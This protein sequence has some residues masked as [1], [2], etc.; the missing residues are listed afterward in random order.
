MR[1]ALSRLLATILP[2][3]L[4]GTGGA[5]AAEGEPPLD[6]LIQLN[7]EELLGAPVEKVE[8]GRVTLDIR[9]LAFNRAFEH[10]STPGRGF[11]ANIEDVK[12]NGSLRPLLHEAEDGF[13]AVGVGNGTAVSKFQFSD[14]FKVSFHLKTGGLSADSVFS[15]RVNQEDAKSFI[16]TDFFRSLLILDKGKK[17]LK[18]TTR[19]QFQPDPPSWFPREKKIPVEISYQGKNQIAVAISMDPKTAR[20]N[21]E[22]RGG[23][24]G[25]RRGKEEAKPGD[26]ERI[27]MV[28]QDGVESPAAGK[29][30]FAFSRVSFLLGNLR[31]EG[32][33]DPAWVE[34]AIEKLRKENKLKIKEDPKPADVAAKDEKAKDTKKSKGSLDG[35]DPEANDEL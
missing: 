35:P 4:I 6:R 29:V 27:E 31:I 21:D 14:D 28:S 2:V 33:L 13:V 16:Q 8:N 5:G 1:Q 17:R 10:R 7:A 11:L 12:K 26:L 15:V 20:G 23:G 30:V 34:A 9:G 19:S 32:K 18:M 3:V 22:K 25:G 24:R